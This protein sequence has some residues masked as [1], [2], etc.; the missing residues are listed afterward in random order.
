MDDGLEGAGGDPPAGL[1]I[2]HLP[3]REV[4]GEVT[5]RGAAAYHPAEGIEDVAEVVDTLSGVLGQQAEIGAD[6]VPL[7]VGSIAGVR[8]VR[9]HTLKYAVDWTK[10]HNTL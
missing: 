10:V 8:L 2:D 7:G 9:D 6:E 5:P 4:L 3:G 1:L